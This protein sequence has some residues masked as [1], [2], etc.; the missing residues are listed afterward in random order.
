MNCFSFGEKEEDITS[1][2]NEEDELIAR[3]NG[4]AENINRGKS[5]S[6]VRLENLSIFATESQAKVIEFPPDMN[7]ILVVKAGPGSG[8]TSTIVKRIAYLIS[9]GKLKPEEI[10]VLSMANRS[11][12][13]LKKYLI[14]TLGEDITSGISINT[15]HS[16][17]G[18]LV[19]QYG[20]QYSSSFRKKTLMDDLSWRSFSN[21]FLGKS[22]SLSGRTVEGNLTPLSLEKLLIAVKSGN[23]T[24]PQAAYKYKVSKEY[25]EALIMYLENNGMIRYHDL[26]VNALELMDLSL[27]PQAVGNMNLIPQLKNYKAIIVDEFQDIHPQLLLIVKAVIEYPT[28]GFCKGDMKHLTIAGDPNQSIYEF[29]GSKPELIHKI[30]DEIPGGE[31]TQLSINESFRITPEILNTVT[32]I[33]LKPAG[34]FDP[35]QEL[36]S[37]RGHGHKPIISMHISNKDEYAFIAS[38]VTRLICEL[39]GLL[40][41]SDFA[42]LTR[43]NKEIEEISK[44][45]TETYNIKC[46]RFS[47]SA[48]WIKSKVHILLDILN[49]ISKGPSSDFGL[50]C[51][52]SI[53]DRKFG[54]SSRVSKLFNVSNKW[55]VNGGLETRENA[56]EEYI[57]HELE[58]LDIQV[59]ENQV[60][61]K[62]KKKSL[63]DI[64]DIYK[65]PKYNNEILRLKT[66]MDS[67]RSVRRDLI[68]N[69]QESQ[70]PT[71]ILSSLLRVLIDLELLEYL[72]LPELSKARSTKQ[73]DSID[74]EKD[75][76]SLLKTYLQSFNKSLKYSYECYM[77]QNSLTKSEKLFVE[78]FLRSYNDE[79][80]TMDR[81]MVNLSTVHTA[82]GLEFPVVFIA[83]APQN[84]KSLSFWDSLLLDRLEPHAQS[85]ARLFYVACTRARNLLYIGTNKRF[86]TLL[87]SAFN[88]LTPELPDM[89]SVINAKYTLLE[90]LAQDLHRKV[91][92]RSK[93]NEGKQLFNEFTSLGLL[94]KKSTNLSQIRQFHTFVNIKPRLYKSFINFGGFLMR[95]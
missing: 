69:T 59:E 68:Q 44:F 82:K 47:L 90:S 8:K 52:I 39:G 88:S 36:R 95:R 13:S 43:S 22:I 48:S 2:S 24:I 41:P 26:L 66:F 25:I 78:Y 6:D 83:G 61:V 10:L 86:D 63:H 87:P 38:E 94:R 5:L 53:L 34:L 12:N 9:I 11:V 46:N 19:D 93:I 91:P 33:C 42:I 3:I 18:G 57:I 84:A 55:K 50:L 20:D 28:S 75:Y 62:K 64:T 92:D 1:I 51:V 56:L 76:K 16:F 60:T 80:P 74:I 73:P 45:L 15:F 72:N 67:I 40:N 27:Q 31:V 29:L 4:D 35:A 23:L 32:E 49:V 89:N 81:E 79:I 54:S 7:K 71:N 14:N 70:N 65:I 37:I 17:C 77:E 21:I 58:F 30:Q 85:K